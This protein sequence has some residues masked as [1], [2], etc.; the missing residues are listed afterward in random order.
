MRLDGKTVTI[1]VTG[2]IAAY[3][4]CELVSRL[5]KSGAA[6]YVVMTENAARFVSPLTFETLSGNRVVKDTFARD[7]EWEVEHVSLAK[8]SDLF[9]VAPCTADVIAKM[10]AGIADDFLSTTALAMRCPILIAP[11]MNTAMLDNA[12]TRDNIAKLE[13]RG[14][15]VIYGGSGF[16]ACGDTGRG[17]MAEPDE[18]YSRIENILFPR[19]DFEGKTLL[20]TAGST[21]EPIDPV[22][23]IGN[24][25]SGK[26]GAAL[27]DCAVRRGA[28]VILI[29]GCMSVSPSE[30]TERTDVTTTCEMYDAVMRNLPRAD[31]VIKAAAPADYRTQQSPQKIKSGEFT[32][33]FI[34][35]PDI[36]AEVGRRKGDKKLVVFCAETENLEENAQKKLRDKNADLVVANDVTKKDAGFDVDTNVATLVTAGKIHP[37][38]V[39]TKKE[40]ADIILD[41]LAEL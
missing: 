34:K 6:V 20:I 36:A 25:S 14:I 28:K 21:R 11:A 16:L 35:N 41:K 33:K 9:A 30:Q 4:T 18:I 7:F 2:G 24:R 3:K 13:A 29:A 15:D 40:L 32:L 23:F 37:L 17:R 10:A 5:R 12:A 8:K 38:P 19:R 31:A 26:M 22:R 39:M 1:G 27:C